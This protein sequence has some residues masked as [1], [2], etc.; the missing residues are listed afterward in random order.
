MSRYLKIV[1]LYVRLGILN[2]LEYRANFF[3][4]LFQSVLSLLLSLGGLSVI[5]SHTGTLNGWTQSELLAVAGVYFIIGGIIRL[6][7]EPSLW[8][9]MQD[10]R[11]GTLD[12]KLLKPVDAQVL[13]SVNQ[14]QMW[15]LIDIVMG[16]GV[17]AVVFA[18]PQMQTDPLRALFFVLA[19]LCGGVIVYSF[20]L[21][22]ATIS[23]W[24]VKVDNI[25]VVF[26][27]MYEAGRYPVGIYPG[28]LRFTLTFLVPV[29]FAVTIP[30]EALTGRLS[31][32][33]LA[34]GGGLALLLAVVSRLFWLYGVRNY[35]GA[36][37]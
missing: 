30:A 36:S 21:M 24:F 15:K 7:I 14:V 16:L 32:E 12:F 27:S 8:R 34:L 18:Q 19:L 33:M 10:V 9:L 6:V 2:E 37:A 28:W 3:V 29:A 31:A 35:T 13:V 11:E 1:A 17:L 4:Q 22:L 25:L 26:E 23:F 5:F 20:Y